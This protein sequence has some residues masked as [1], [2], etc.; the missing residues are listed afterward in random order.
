MRVMVVVLHRLVLQ[1]TGGQGERDRESEPQAEAAEAV[2]AFNTEG[3]ETDDTGG[4]GS[5]CTCAA[6]GL[7]ENRDRTTH[8]GTVDPRIIEAQV[9]VQRSHLR[10]FFFRQREIQNGKVLRQ[11][12]RVR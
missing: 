1:I 5:A 4:R 12:G 7:I 9:L 2:H 11:M 10:H 3:T 6:L 8:K